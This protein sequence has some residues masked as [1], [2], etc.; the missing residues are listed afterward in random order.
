MAFFPI[1][2]KENLNLDRVLNEM[3]LHIGFEVNGRVFAN[4]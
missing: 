1:S 2:V 3:L 4:R